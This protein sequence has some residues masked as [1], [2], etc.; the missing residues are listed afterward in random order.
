MR[1]IIPLIYCQDETLLYHLSKNSKKK[2]SQ[3]Y[4]KHVKFHI[5]LTEKDLKCS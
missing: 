1:L 3:K 5:L 2:K 4:L